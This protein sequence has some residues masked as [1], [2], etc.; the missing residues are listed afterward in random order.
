M[1]GGKASTRSQASIVARV[2]GMS[3]A[4]YLW[5]LHRMMRIILAGYRKLIAVGES[6]DLMRVDAGYLTLF[7]CEDHEVD[8]VVVAVVVAVAVAVAAEM[9]VLGRH[10]K[11]VVVRFEADIVASASESLP[12]LV[13][14]VFSEMSRTRWSAVWTGGIVAT[15]ALLWI[16]TFITILWL[17]L[18][19]V[20]GL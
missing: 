2:V 15:R 4:G 20:L 17:A 1:S 6:M 7:D 5:D 19:T 3:G 11:T 18:T 10:M 13:R 8:I 14:G 12:L 9:T 16:A